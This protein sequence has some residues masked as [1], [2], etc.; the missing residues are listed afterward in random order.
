MDSLVW[1]I[2]S[3]IVIVAAKFCCLKPEQHRLPF[4]IGDNPFGRRSYMWYR[5]FFDFNW[6]AICIKCH[7][8][9]VCHTIEGNC[10]QP[11][12]SVD[13]EGVPNVP[14]SCSCPYDIADDPIDYVWL[15][16]ILLFLLLIF[17]NF[18]AA[19][20]FATIVSAAIFVT[21]VVGM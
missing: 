17:T 5:G 15:V 9:M 19:M 18:G 6:K 13:Y 11:N 3:V 21:L 1:A 7:H 8:T 14:F 20:I 10:P 4:S 16:L 2:L 12:L